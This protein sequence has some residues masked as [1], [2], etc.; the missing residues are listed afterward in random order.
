MIKPHIRYVLLMVFASVNFL[1]GTAMAQTSARHST[2]A[3]QAFDVLYNSI[4]RMVLGSGIDQPAFAAKLRQITRVGG[5]EVTAVGEYKHSSGGRGLMRMNL[6]SPDEG[7][8]S[9][10]EQTCDGRLV[11][12]REEVGGDVRI[13]RV[14]VGRLDE[15]APT[16]GIPPRLM[17][18]GLPELLD[19]VAWDYDLKLTKANLR[20]EQM[21]WV[22]R[23]QLKQQKLD[24]LLEQSGASELPPEMPSRVRIGLLKDGPFAWLPVRIEFFAGEGSSFTEPAISEL[25][26]YDMRSIAT[27]REET[28]RYN[29]KEGALFTNETQQYLERYRV[30]L[31][32]RG[33][34]GMLR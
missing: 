30:R 3:Q 24:E 10:F 8:T 16:T 2:N 27:P 17:V 18:G 19:A 33:T 29:T 31:A 21:V 9:R 1:P 26:V 6:R 32:S 14:D 11:W 12:T 22:V 15:F 25:D 4:N 7:K 20:E 23:G 13:R 28:F 5:Q 34:R